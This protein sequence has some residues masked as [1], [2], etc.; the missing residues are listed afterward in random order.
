MIY[1]NYK[2][3]FVSQ[4]IFFQISFVFCTFLAI[5]RKM[6]FSS[7]R[8]ILYYF[9]SLSLPPSLSFCVSKLS[10]INQYRV[11]LF[12]SGD[13]IRF[14]SCLSVCTQYLMPYCPGIHNFLHALRPMVSI[15]GFYG[16]MHVSKPLEA[17]AMRYGSGKMPLVAQNFG[18]TCYSEN[19]FNQFSCPCQ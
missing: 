5:N 18:M 19:C 6:S 15:P 8:K 17:G 9:L 12:Q 4:R 10:W 11:N 1:F 2:S 3:L 16:C 7:T 14:S 13:D